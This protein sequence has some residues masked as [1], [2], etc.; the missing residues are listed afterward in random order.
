M[1]AGFTRLGLTYRP[2]GAPWHRSHCQNPFA[3]DLGEGRQRIHFACR[4]EKN[5]SQG[6]WAEIDAG[7][8]VVRAFET[9]SLTIGRPG[10]FDDAGAMPGCLVAH[11]GRLRLYY[12]GWTLAK[13]VPF[14]FFIGLAESADGGM[15]FAKVSEAP[16][17]GRNHHDPFLTG[18]PWVLREG[19]RYRMWYISGTEWVIDPDE[20]QAPVHYYTIK[21]A[22]SRDGIA[23]ET[24]DRLCLP[25]LEGEHA[26]A[27]PVVSRT[28][29]GYEMLY[30][31]RRLGETYRIYRA[32][33]ADGLDWQR[34]PAPLLDTAASGWDSEMVCYG[35]WMTTPAGPVLLYNGNA[36]GR[37]GFGI[38]RPAAA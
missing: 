12:T 8:N 11:E 20:K 22:A 17:L 25:Y 3:Q 23:W 16:V 24:A 28:S 30:S 35:S 6:G 21:H 38:A 4:D 7:F 32:T 14:T 10:A 37:D 19:E 31:A 5:R 29:T 34:D 18:A 27:R 36:Y 9:P 1:T 33:S 26:V 2:T 15:S 13:T